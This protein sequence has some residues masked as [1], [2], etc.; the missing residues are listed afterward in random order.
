MAYWL[1]NGVADPGCQGVSTGK[2]ICGEF[3]GTISAASSLPTKSAFIDKAAGI[4]ELPRLSGLRRVLLQQNSQFRPG[5]AGIADKAAERHWRV[6]VQ[7]NQKIENESRESGLLARWLWRYY[8]KK[9]TPKIIVALVFMSI[10][11]SMLGFL[12]YMIGPMFDD[13]F[14]ERDKAALLWLGLAILLIFSLRGFAGLVQRV[15]M[16]AVGE[17]VRLELQRDLMRHVLTLDTMFFEANPP[18]NLMERILGDSANIQSVWSRLVSPA[19]RDVISLVSL[20]GVAVAIDPVWTL[21]AVAGIPLLLG[22]VV[23]M[24]RLTRRYSQ[25]QRKAATAINVR[26]DEIFH[27]IRIIKLNI[28][29][30]RQV[31]RFLKSAHVRRRAS[32]RTEASQASVPAMF[33][34]IGGLGFLG[35]LLVGGSDVIEGERTIGQFM[36]FFT[37]VV[38]LFDPVKR[39]GQVATAWHEVKVSLER[40]YVLREAQPSIQNPLKSIPVPNDLSSADI[41]FQGVGFGF[42]DTPILQDLSF[43]ARSGRTTAI[44]GRSGAGK[45]T[46]FNLMTRIFDP[47][48]GS[49]T[50]GGKAIC[51]FEL[52]ELR[53]LFAVVAQDTGIFDETIR[54]NILLGNP[55]ATDEEVRR[56]ADAAHVTEFLDKLP[57]GLDSECGPRGSNL[58]GGQRQRIAIARALLRNAPILLFDE[59]IGALD[60]QSEALVQNAIASLTEGRTILVIAHKLETVRDADKIIVMDSGTATEQG[61]HSDLMS[62]GGLYA[63]L[64][65]A[66]FN[67]D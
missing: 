29:E 40:V 44:V 51:E 24:Q 1:H 53:G 36:S 21:I 9:H 4:S 2:F 14:M 54:D 6:H 15:I 30:N 17:R 7:V 55:D 64:Y 52:S 18:G 46:V 47:S 65:Q 59:H 5:A 48:S 22:P 28:Q 39:L 49:I 57:E 56:V 8:L 66:Q 34:L 11:G 41:E 38:L 32:V 12:S 67:D 31:D 60:T 27:G 42:D 26:L 25:V 62:R 13:V 45:T 16:A 61:R 58:S 63:K 20:V 10:Q 23:I 19:V 43:L 33:E 50:I 3:L 37:A 35:F